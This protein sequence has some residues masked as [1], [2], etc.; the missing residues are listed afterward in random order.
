MSGAVEAKELLK[1]HQIELLTYVTKDIY[2]A[3]R[4]SRSWVNSTE[5]GVPFMGS[6]DILA[7]DLS[8]LPLISKKQI[9]SNPKF[10][11]RNG[12][13][14]ITRS[15]TVGRMAFA[16][17][18]MDGIACSEHV[19]RV[20]PNEDLIKSGYLYAYLSSSFGV[21]IVIAGTYGAIIQHI[22]PEHIA[23]LPV[24]RL[25]KVENQAHDL[26]Q[27][28][29]DMRTAAS[30]SIS[31]AIAIMERE[32]GLMGLSQ[33]AS[34]GIGFGV[35]T[36]SSSNLIKRMDAGFHSPFHSDVLDAFDSASVDTCTVADIALSIEEPKR[37]KRVHINDEE[38]GIPMFGTSALMWADPQ[39]SF[40]IPKQ[41]AVEYNLT[42]NERTLL[43]P[44]SG[45]LS[46]IIG[47][48]VLPYGKVI[49]GAVSEDAIRIHCHNEIDAGFLFVA[50]KAECGR[51]QLKARAY[52]SSIPHLDVYQIGQIIVPKLK[53]NI[54][55]EIG[56]IGFR[57]SELRSQA[58]SLENKAR[59]LVERA[60]EEGGR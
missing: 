18:D 50:L 7:S 6:T 55:N 47:T 34:S 14:L 48:A 45:Q 9:A 24:P 20:V 10:T 49:G 37:F 27:R 44:R 52:G 38:F 19:M 46:G 30:K 36:V 1:R 57:S 60:I 13:T 35:R 15:G 21:P 53:E 42:V 23:E 3:G 12:W 25:G 33:N 59:D 29:A 17:S 39:P 4:E 5:H 51:R 31:E 11:I 16:R 22:E 58:I 26:V 8:Y 43:I 40:L 54:H 56:R 41:I 28:A 32:S 2:H